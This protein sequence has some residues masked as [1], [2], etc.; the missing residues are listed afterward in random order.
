MIEQFDLG[1]CNVSLVHNCTF[2]DLEHSDFQCI[3]NGAGFATFTDNE[4][5]DSITGFRFTI[6]YSADLISK[7]PFKPLVFSLNSARI[8]KISRGIS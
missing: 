5:L 7:P 6:N 2:V 3:Q 4:I 8:G 1:F